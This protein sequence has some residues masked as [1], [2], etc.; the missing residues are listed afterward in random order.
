MNRVLEIGFFVFLSGLIG[1]IFLI[2]IVSQHQSSR[3]FNIKDSKAPFWI[4]IDG[5][6][7]FAGTYECMSSMRFEEVLQRALPLDQADLSFL[8]LHRKIDHS[9]SIYV[10]YKE[11]FSDL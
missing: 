7:R 2:S 5:A 9:F 11:K 6:V 1:V 10:P 8:P 3:V 4:H